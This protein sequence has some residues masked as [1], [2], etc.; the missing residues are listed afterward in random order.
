MTKPRKPLV[1][2]TKQRAGLQIYERVSIDAADESQEAADA[3]GQVLQA[4][5]PAGRLMRIKEGARR[6]PNDALISE[7]IGDVED[8]LQACNGNPQT[9]DTFDRIDSKLKALERGIALLDTG[10]QLGNV[11]TAIGHRAGQSNRAKKPRP[12]ISTDDGK[13]SQED[14]VKRAWRDAGPYAGTRDVWPHLF[15]V[16]DVLGFLPVR[17]GAKEEEKYHFNDAVG[18][19]QTMTWKGVQRMLG[20]LKREAGVESELGRP[21][22]KP[23]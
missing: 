17:A 6:H 8:L 3:I 4:A 9:W 18:K 11:F 1:Q 12:R 16:L 22:K 5:S 13:V 2:R 10:R 14:L 15:S 19:Q 7:E 21:R 23:A 20:V